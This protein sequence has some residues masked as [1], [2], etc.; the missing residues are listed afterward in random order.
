MIKVTAQIPRLEARRATK[1]LVKMSLLGAKAGIEYVSRAQALRIAKGQGPDGPQRR[2][3]EATRRQKLKDGYPPTPLVRRG[4]YADASM[5]RLRPVLRGYVL[6][7]PAHRERAFAAHKRAGFQF[8]KSAAD[9]PEVQRLQA[10]ALS[11][12]QL[13]RY[14]RQVQV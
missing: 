12:W 1:D 10:K 14:A 2:I 6:L 9:L 5:W 13:S 4:S 11:G 3:A 8:G 7:P